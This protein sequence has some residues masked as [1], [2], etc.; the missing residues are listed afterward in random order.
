MNSMNHK[1]V[2]IQPSFQLNFKNYI[3]TIIDETDDFKDVIAKFYEF[4]ISEKGTVLFQAI[5]DGCVDVIFCCNSKNPF[6]KVYGSVKHR[7]MI[8]LL[9][10]NKYFGIRFM[11]GAARGFLNYSIN[12][13]TDNEILLTDVLSKH[14]SIV[15][16]ISN[17]KSYLDRICIFKE[18]LKNFLTISYKP[19][20]II[21]YSLDKI[22]QSK[23]IININDLSKEL[24][25]STR[26]IR[27]NFQTDVGISP[28][29]L[30]QIIR[31]Q[32]SLNLILTNTE[33][34]IM[35]IVFECGYYDQA[36]LINEFKK[37]TNYTP[38]KTEYI[39]IIE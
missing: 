12:E 8:E 1:Y 13:F 20:E 35:D 32:H 15:E 19:S 23:G 11:P 38:N 7:K 27:K 37:F 10:N 33:H 29:L 2:P 25:Y 18:Y 22:T 21:L 24:G 9:G 16:K 3:D 4:E 17:A 14:R 26:Y 5:P 36:H 28:K 31:F 6:A 34:N 39:F 30:S